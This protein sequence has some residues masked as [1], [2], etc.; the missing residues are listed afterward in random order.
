L[1]GF[2]V[3]YWNGSSWVTVPNGNVAGNNK[4][5]TKLVF[6]PITTTKI[7]VLVNGALAS[8]SRIVELEAWSGGS[9]YIIP[10]SPE[11]NGSKD[12]G[13]TF[14]ETLSEWISNAVTFP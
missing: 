7:R 11:Q 4:V 1:T 10:T 9:N 13:G 5:I 6:S 3:Q 2:D 8:Y 14:I 12:G